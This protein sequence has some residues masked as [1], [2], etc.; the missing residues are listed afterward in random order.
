M[1][2]PE[3]LPIPVSLLGVAAILALSGTLEKAMV[4]PVAAFF[5]LAGQCSM[6]IFVMHIL[7]LG[8]VRTIGLRVLGFQDPL[9]LMPPAIALAVLA[10][11]AAQVIAARMGLH[12]YLGWTAP[13]MTSRSGPAREPKPS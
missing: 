3:R 7:V 9:V 11:M 5:Q 13:T 4:R 8:F 6:S 12:G 10:P 1:D 2:I